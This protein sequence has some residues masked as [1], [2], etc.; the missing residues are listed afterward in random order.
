MRSLWRKDSLCQ[1]KFLTETTSDS[2]SLII[3]KKNK[4]ES[5]LKLLRWLFYFD[6]DQDLITAQC[7]LKELLVDQNE[8]HTAL[9]SNV[10]RYRK[11]FHLSS[12]S[13]AMIDMDYIIAG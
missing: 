10:Y 7:S 8:R 13:P 11:L 2:P 4:S 6:S 5:Y 3:M 12:R 1:R 9:G